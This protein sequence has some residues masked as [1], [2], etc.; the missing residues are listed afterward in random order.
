MLSAKKLCYPCP[1]SVGRHFPVRA[2]CRC[3]RRSC[4][5]HWRAAYGSV[6]WS[7]R[8][9]DA[10]DSAVG[11]GVVGGAIVAGGV[12]QIGRFGAFPQTV[13]FAD[14]RLPEPERAVLRAASVQFPVWTEADRVHRAKVAFERF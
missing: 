1:D 8:S 13:R 3:Y 5:R 12:V 14:G 4:R 11:G 10:T 6:V 7:D 2:R 9:D